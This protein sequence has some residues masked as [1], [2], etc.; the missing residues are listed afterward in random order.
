MLSFPI[1]LC[2]V[3]INKHFNIEQFIYLF[4]LSS[5]LTVPL[6][7][8]TYSIR[9]NEFQYQTFDI[10]KYS[11]NLD[12]ES[13]DSDDSVKSSDSDEDQIYIA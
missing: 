9:D 6:L 8:C 4:I 13:E 2:T 5:V 11:Q 3:S 12:Q 10:P 1:L 7:V